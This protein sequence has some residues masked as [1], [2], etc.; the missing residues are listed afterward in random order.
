[1]RDL[2][3]YAAINSRIRA[4]SSQFLCPRIW[5]SLLAAHDIA[6]LTLILQST[7][8][9]SFIR[10]TIIQ[11]KDL[12]A[13]EQAFLIDDV[14]TH[15]KIIKAWREKGHPGK[16]IDLLRERYEL[17]EVKVL[18]RCW[19]AQDEASVRPHIFSEAFVHPIPI[20]RVFSAKNFN[21]LVDAFAGTPYRHVLAGAATRYRKTGSLFY[22]EAAMDRDYFNRLWE[23]ID[24]LPHADRT[25]AARLVGVE[26]DM[27]NI[28][29]LLRLRRYYDFPSGDL[30]L[31]MLPRGYRINERMLR[32]AFVKEGFADT[33]KDMAVRPY[34]DLGA[35]F[36]KAMDHAGLSLLEGVLFQTLFSEARRVMRG[37]PFTI[38]TILAYLILKRAETRKLMSIFYGKNHGFSSDRIK[39]ALLC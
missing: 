39:G 15:D 29:G 17:S 20:D 8:Y 38:G 9:A 27:E 35:L 23:E 28:S 12:E 13:L 1:M 34:Q 7:P 11:N 2:A 3:T 18:L 26:V 5:D 6:D 36:A 16:V 22:L 4:M 37:F 30:A 10:D 25:A 32:L 33:L 21:E 14:R 24:C 19:A 31:I